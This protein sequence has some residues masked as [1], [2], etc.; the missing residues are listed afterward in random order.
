VVLLLLVGWFTYDGDG[1]PVSGI[2]DALAMITRGARLTR[3]PYDPVTGV[4]PGTPTDLADEAGLTE[5]QYA[6]ARMISSEEGSSDNTIKA[7]VCWATINYAAKVGKSIVELLTHAQNPA[8]SGRFG[9]QKDIDPS[10]PNKGKSDRYASTALDPYDGDGQI[11]SQCLDGTIA[12]FTNGATN[13]D[14]PAG[15]KNPT[16]VA[17]N[18]ANEGL[19][20]IDVPGIDSS[21]IRF[22]G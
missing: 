18:R 22:W 14:R 5:D 11:A 3:A 13:F 1:D 8:H 17:Q 10:S 19:S 21:Q 15:E 9:T 4:V 20:P 2:L 6:L 16:K 7:A 12:D